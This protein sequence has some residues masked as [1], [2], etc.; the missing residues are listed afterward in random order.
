MIMQ[1]F[2]IIVEVPRGWYGRLFQVVDPEVGPPTLHVS[3]RPLVE[4]DDSV[5]NFATLTRG[6]MGAGDVTIVLVSWSR[7]PRSVFDGLKIDR[8]AST[9]LVQIG[10]EHFVPVQGVPS[11]QT[12]AY[13]LL[14][15][16]GRYLSLLVVFGS[17][18]PSSAR[19]KDVNA[20]LASLVIGLSREKE[21]GG[22]GDLVRF[23]PPAGL[24]A[25]PAETGAAVE[26]GQPVNA[27]G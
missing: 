27:G 4:R 9:G 22:D 3:S 7:E 1:D 17:A 19:I 26:T 14:T 18:N 11:T 15:M 20:I 8:I 5:S 25:A 10:A 12:A 24:D 13:R 16:N 21:I 2:G 23:V 6:A